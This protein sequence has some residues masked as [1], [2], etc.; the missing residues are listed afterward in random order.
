MNFKKALTILLLLLLFGFLGQTKAQ[1]PADKAQSLFVQANDAFRKANATA[2]AAEQARLYE[3]AILNYEKLIDQG[4]TENAKLYYNLANTYFLHGDLGR[5]ILNYRRAQK[6]DD[7]DA[8]IKKN[9]AFARSRRVDKVAVPTKSK[10]FE[11]LLFWHYD[12]SLR[13]KFTLSCAFFALLCLALTVIVWRGRSVA[14]VTIVIVSAI[15]FICFFTSVL[16][17]ANSQAKS[18][19]GV[20]TAEK[21]VAR[22]GDGQNYPPSFKEPLHA[23]TEFDLL[24][25]RPGWLHIRLGDGSEGWIPHTAAELI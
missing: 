19:C 25:H 3:A 4:K 24:E 1:L 2:D 17:Q 8:N 16:L 10:V 14:P 20:I 23:G 18:I 7:S 21:I 6:L 5:A 9:L 22:Q 15:L 11:T 13:T 12:F